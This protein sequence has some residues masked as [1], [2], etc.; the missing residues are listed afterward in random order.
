MNVNETMENLKSLGILKDEK[1]TSLE[2]G[3]GRETT[4]TSMTM[5]DTDLF[6]RGLEMIRQTNV[7]NQHI[8]GFNAL[9]LRAGASQGLPQ[10]DE[11]MQTGRGYVHTD[12]MDE[13]Y[14]MANSETQER[15]DKHREA[16]R[17]GLLRQHQQNQDAG[18]LLDEMTE[19]SAPK[20]QNRTVLQDNYIEQKSSARFKDVLD[21]IVPKRAFASPVA[22]SMG[23]GAIGFGAMWAATA[24]FKTAPTPEGMREQQAQG[25]GP[26][27]PMDRLLT[28]PTARITENNGEHI[29]LQIS[30]KDA[31]N[32]SHSEV[33]AM[34][35]QELQGMSAVQMNM[36]LNVNDNSQQIDQKWVQDLVANAVGKG[37]AF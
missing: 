36:N 1:T 32:M 21:N 13:Y 33:A 26:Q 12:A 15:M 6:E 31:K 19:K 22:G 25:G 16:Y 29:N 14:R 4:P 35:N 17:S 30:A 27:V 28:S 18:N 2:I 10:F 9:A 34:V 20:L 8:G 7:K 5:K 11:M 3:L 24:A 37:Y 23:A